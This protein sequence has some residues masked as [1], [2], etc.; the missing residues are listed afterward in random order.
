MSFEQPRAYYGVNIQRGKG[1]GC[2]CDGVEGVVMEK[3]RQ[4][5][6]KECGRNEKVSLVWRGLPSMANQWLVIR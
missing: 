5:L 3:W 4:E 6:S 1:Y 2:F